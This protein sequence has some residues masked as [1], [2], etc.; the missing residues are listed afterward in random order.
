[1]SPPLLVQHGLERHAGHRLDLGDPG[2]GR[3]VGGGGERPCLLAGDIILSFAEV[4]DLAERF[5]RCLRERGVAPGDRVALLL[6][7]SPRYVAAFHGTLKAGAVAVPLDP[8][9]GAA[10]WCDI[11]ERCAPALVVTENRLAA[12][13]AASPLPQRLGCLTFTGSLDP[14]L[15]SP[16]SISCVDRA[17]RGRNPLPPSEELSAHRHSEGPLL[18]AKHPLRRHSDGPLLR[19]GVHGRLGE[20]RRAAKEPAQRA[21]PEHRPEESPGRPPG[22]Q[23]PASAPPSPTTVDPLDPLDLAAL[24]PD[25]RPAGTRPDDPAVILFTSGSTGLP[26]GVVLTHRNVVANT[27]AV[28][29][30][31]HLNPADRGLAVLPFHYVYGQSV[32]LTHLWAGASLAIENRAAYPQV[33]L[34][35]MARLG[36]TG[37]SGVPSTFMLLLQKGD[38]STL[39]FPR[40]RYLTCAGGHLP[41]LHVR[42]LG[43]RF[44][45]AD[46]YL[47]Y[48]ATEAAGRISYL[49]P[50]LLARKRGSIG[51][52]IRGV[53]M[54]VMDRG[55]PAG[56]F[57]NGEIEARGETFSPGYWPLADPA[58]RLPRDGWYRTGDL[59]YR[60]EEGC[61]FLTGRAS[62]LIKIAG[63]R[64]SGAE[65]ER[66]LYDTGLVHECAVAGRPDEVLGERAEAWIVPARPGISPAEVLAALAPRLPAWKRPSRIHLQEALEK[67]ASGKILK[68][69]LR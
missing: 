60:D 18:S 2:D 14:H 5:A 34:Q 50:A 20:L 57:E 4:D 8:T 19:E 49:P 7:N 25:P 68:G 33:I 35:E 38:F 65:I 63:H 37:L 61:F 32:L 45:A 58:D 55:R 26:K 10:S 9:A 56:P 21:T 28:L 67:S 13:L 62:D 48:G 36:V 30:Y 64:V 11:A 27:L 69:A 41:D 54:R 17:R 15:P 29:D 12:A 31:L 66:A 53:E 43:Q 52:P 46:L 44:P 39:Q 1:V 42:G 16:E 22:G 23:P 59:G 51:R 3:D 47:M 40:L 6:G 24:P